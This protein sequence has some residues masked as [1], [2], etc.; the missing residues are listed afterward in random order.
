MSA[1]DTLDAEPAAAP[2][3][4]APRLRHDG[5]TPERQRRFL[6]SIAEGHTV[7]DACRTV[8][9]SVASAYALRRRAAGAG[10][11]LGWHGA[12][13]LARERIA[14]TLLARAIHG[15]TETGTRP[16]AAPGRATATTTA[17]PPACSRASTPRP[18]IPQL[19]PPIA[20]RAWSRRSS[21]P[22]SIC[23][24][25]T[26]APPAQRCSSPPVPT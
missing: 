11:A 12:N 2:S 7:E 26:P 4:E 17:S 22:S 24:P 13:L 3:A 20:P 19:A 10:F 9:L 23:S 15:Q 5:W 18:T 14:D 8:G 25:A 1:P 6:E 16:T 21:T